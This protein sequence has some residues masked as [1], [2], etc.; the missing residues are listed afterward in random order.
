MSRKI[1]KARRRHLLDVVMS[2]SFCRRM[3]MMKLVR[4]H[5]EHE[6]ML[7]RVS[8]TRVPALATRVPGNLAPG[9]YV[10]TESGIVHW[11]KA[12]S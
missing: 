1:S 12:A 4:R 7:E 8:R 5:L 10:F 3:R 11:T 2:E 9:L 6:R